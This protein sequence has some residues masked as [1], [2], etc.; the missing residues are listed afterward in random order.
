M[1]NSINTNIGAQVALRNLNT[2]NNSLSE[3][4]NRVSTGL[5]V[6]SAKDDAS[7]FAVAQGI[8]ADVKSFEAVQQAL[9]SAKGVVSVAIESTT[10]I[11]N[12]MAD[13][14]TKLVSLSDESL[15]SEQREIYTDDL[16]QLLLQVDSFIDRA[17]FNGV[18]ILKA[19]EA[20]E[21]GNPLDDTAPQDLNVVQSVD[22]DSLTV[23]ARNLTGVSN[24][25][26]SSAPTGYM[27]FARIAFATDDD[28]TANSDLTFNTSA[29]SFTVRTSISADQARAALGNYDAAA[30]TD[31]VFQDA[32]DNFNKEV[33]LALGSLGADNRNLDFQ[34]D[35]NNALLDSNEEGLGSLVDADLAKESARLQALQTKQQLAI[36][37][38]SIANTSTQSILSL[39]GG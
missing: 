8:R 7:T 24:A 12:V 37:T 22:G 5:K 33:N 16:A 1:S 9:S 19:V 26:N 29:G 38:L 10:N 23:R 31:E 25:T 32:W 28:D 21:T 3:V 36:Q 14:K 2:V 13:V 17:S 4:Q 34:K 20:G 39:F 27:A 15:K 35:F 18:N 30:T 11:S 6:S